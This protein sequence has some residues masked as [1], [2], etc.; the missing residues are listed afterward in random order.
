MRVKSNENALA[1]SLQSAAPR[2]HLAQLTT[3]T[4]LLITQDH[5]LFGTPCSSEFIQETLQRTFEHLSSLQKLLLARQLG[6][7]SFSSMLAASTVVTLSD[8][9]AW[10]LTADRYGAWTAWNLCR[11]EFSRCDQINDE[12]PTPPKKPR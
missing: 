3:S 4:R 10:W 2:R 11:I 7:D 5:G 6:Y 8:G 1:S 12:A 9:S